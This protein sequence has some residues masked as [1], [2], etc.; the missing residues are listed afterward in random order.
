MEGDAVFCFGTLEQQENR[1]QIVDDEDR[2]L[3]PL[4][5]RA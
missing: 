4:R 2:S 5:D 3:A 1:S